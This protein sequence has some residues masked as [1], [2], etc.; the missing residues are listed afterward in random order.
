MFVGAR[1]FVFEG[2][3]SDDFGLVL[4]RFQGNEPSSSYG[5]GIEF[6]KTDRPI[7]NRWYKTGNSYYKE[8]IQFY[9]QV[10]KA[11]FK[12]FDAY[13]YSI[14]SRW[15]QRKDSYKD[16]MIVRTDYDNIHFNVMLNT[17]PIA[18]SGNIVGISVSAICDSAFG[19]GHMFK[20][21]VNVNGTA[22]FTILDMSDEIGYIY[23]DCR[24]EVQN[25]CDVIVTN[26]TDNR[27]FRINKCVTGE[28]ISID[29]KYLEASTTA[30]LHNLYNNFNYKFIRITNDY[31]NRKNKFKLEGNFI[32]TM[33][34]RPVRKVMI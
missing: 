28:I 24:I 3:T 29:G 30:L 1:G 18:V 32:F 14:I 2:K 34:Y 26:I 25:D 31:N 8:P 16:F 17:E 5:G 4:C 10:V 19:Y 23:P 15:L 22:E 27:V 9:F 21:T 7:Q 11:N 13:E 20:K 6:S 12:P 33:Q